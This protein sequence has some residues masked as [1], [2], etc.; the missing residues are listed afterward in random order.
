M[1][2]IF[3][4]LM[5]FGSTVYWRL[6]PKTDKTDT[7]KLWWLLYDITLMC[8]IKHRRVQIHSFW[9]LKMVIQILCKN[10]YWF[11]FKSIF[12]TSLNQAL[13]LS[14]KN[15]YLDIVELLLYH[16]AEDLCLSCNSSQ[17]W[18]SFHQT[19]LQTIDSGENLH[20]LTLYF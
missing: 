17:Y 3:A 1:C 20:L 12:I 15:G 16:G 2:C 13:Y 5:H 9:Q 4:K 18:T 6:P 8:L 10:S 19:R 7:L 11:K 14:A